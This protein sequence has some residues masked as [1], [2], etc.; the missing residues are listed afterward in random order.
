MPCQQVWQGPDV[1]DLD[2]TIQGELTNI[3]CRDEEIEM[4]YNAIQNRAEVS[5]V[6]HR[7]ILATILQ[8]VRNYKR[9]N[10]GILTNVHFPDPRMRQGQ[11]DHF[12]WW[13]CQPWS[14]AIAR[15]Y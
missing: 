2:S 1:S 14:H 12:I 7:F 5:L 15:R 13:C 6:D 4:I 8:E 3:L 11:D 9:N 10:S